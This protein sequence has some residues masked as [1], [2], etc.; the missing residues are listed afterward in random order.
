[1][2]ILAKKK[3]KKLNEQWMNA[4]VCITNI[5]YYLK[6]DLDG[7]E[8]SKHMICIAQDLKINT[9]LYFNWTW[10]T[11][12]RHAKAF[13]MNRDQSCYTVS[14]AM[15]KFLMNQDCLTFHKAKLN[16]FRN[17]HDSLKATV[18]TL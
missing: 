16:E 5:K 1:M 7:E 14:F 8:S 17:A 12:A 13:W 6:N 11:P 9:T 4:L 15:T 2:L 18:Y 3:K 10:T